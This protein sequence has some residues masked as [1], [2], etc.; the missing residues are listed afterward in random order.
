MFIEIGILTLLL[1]LNGFFAMSE[2]AIVS[3]R[4]A[5][6]KQIS[7][8]NPKGAKLALSLVEDP[9]TFLSIIQVGV[10]LNSIMAGAL[11]GATLAD[12]LA[13]YL[14][15]F[16]LI[17]PYEETVAIFVTVICVTYLNLVIGELLPKRI[18]L[19]YAEEIAVKISPFMC[20]LVRSLSPVV[21]TLKVSTEIMLKVMRLNNHKAAS[22]TEDEVKNLITEGAESG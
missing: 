5:R 8:D 7:E 16:N 15:Q 3:S 13:E 1:L 18:G 9:T 14:R 22:V 6:L 4:R 17:Y 10:T 2:L 20:W 12:R 19:S 21:W 11:S